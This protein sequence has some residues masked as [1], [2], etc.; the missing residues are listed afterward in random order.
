MRFG[1][2]RT[3]HRVRR[4]GRLEEDGPRTP[5][6]SGAQWSHRHGAGR[7]W[8]A[9]RAYR[10]RHLHGGHHF[11]A[12]L[13]GEIIEPFRLWA[14]SQTQYAP[15][16][17]DNIV[18]VT[19]P[20][21]MIVG[22]LLEGGISFGNLSLAV[23]RASGFYPDLVMGGAAPGKVARGFYRGG[24]SAH[25]C[26]EPRALIAGR[27]RQSDRRSWR[28]GS[29]PLRHSRGHGKRKRAGRPPSVHR[30]TE[31]FGRRRN[32]KIDPRTRDRRFPGPSGIQHRDVLQAIASR[33]ADVAIIFHHLARYSAE[34]YP[35][36]CQMVTVREAENFSSTIAMA[37]AVDPL[38][39]RAAK[40][41]S[42]FFFKIAREVYPRYGFAAMGESEF[43]RTI[44]LED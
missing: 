33:Y 19:L 40:A 27:G 21:P 8:P 36:L 3:R 28:R 26:A 9:G 30:R 32:R 14:K 34:A 37:L 44:R 24:A 13:G 16:G 1:T 6:G 41:F 25:L 12:L 4:C 42:E 31:R 39:A 5:R 10:P 29:C 43:G 11:P 2:R 23:S 35:Q 22:M 20:Q 17:L 38:R 18:I 15:L 7:R